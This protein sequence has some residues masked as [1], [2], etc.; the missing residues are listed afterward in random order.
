MQ[1]GCNFVGA[2]LKGN[3]GENVAYKWIQNHGVFLIFIFSFFM[4][5]IQKGSKNWSI[6]YFGDG[7]ANENVCARSFSWHSGE[8]VIG[9]GH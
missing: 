7:L 5:H 2:F 9:A 6:L 1:K 8:K 4:L 3:V